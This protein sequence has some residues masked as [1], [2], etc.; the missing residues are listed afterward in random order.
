MSMNLQVNDEAIKHWH[1]LYSKFRV[2]ANASAAKIQLNA[3]IVDSEK[4]CDVIPDTLTA[5]FHSS[6][7]KERYYTADWLTQ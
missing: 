3:C 2:L 7:H 4:S 5:T 6:C 1:S